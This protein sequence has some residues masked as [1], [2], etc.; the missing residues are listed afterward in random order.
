[1]D[2]PYVH[3]AKSLHITVI[4]MCK[5]PQIV[6]TI[7]SANNSPNIHTFV[8]KDRFLLT[9]WLLDGHSSLRKF[10]TVEK[11]N[12]PERTAMSEMLE[13]QSNTGREQSFKS[14][15]L[16][17]QT[18][19]SCYMITFRFPDF[20]VLTLN[21]LLFYIGGKMRCRKGLRF[22]LWS[23][24]ILHSETSQQWHAFVARS[25]KNKIIMW[26]H[27]RSTSFCVSCKYDLDLTSVLC[28]VSL[29]FLQFFS[30][31]QVF[32]FWCSLIQ[33]S[34]ENNKVHV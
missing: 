16:F 19:S 7:L 20:L 9:E 27:D 28:C 6:N 22:L 2:I 3:G 31:V 33:K 18:G 4:L 15:A 21:I 5:C 1:M 8:R 23:G 10:D 13:V 30:N 12:N 11:H 25:V 32:S 26:T 29:T 24:N 34:L 14:P 17:T